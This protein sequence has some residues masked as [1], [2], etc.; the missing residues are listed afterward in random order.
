MKWLKNYKKYSY[1]TSY[2]TDKSRQIFLLS[3]RQLVV[4]ES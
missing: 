4:L 3:I 2:F 1:R